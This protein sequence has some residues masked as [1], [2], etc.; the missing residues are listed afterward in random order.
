MGEATLRCTTQC[1]WVGM[2]MSLSFLDAARAL[3]QAGEELDPA[4]IARLIDQE[5]TEDGL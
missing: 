5:V 2:I 4:F 1:R 3:L